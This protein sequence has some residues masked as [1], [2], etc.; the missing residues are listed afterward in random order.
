M[1]GQRQGGV[2]PARH[3]TGVILS[4]PEGTA[5]AQPFYCPFC[6]EEDF[7]P[8]ENPGEYYCESCNRRFEVKMLGLGN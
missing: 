2:R 6:G 7:I 8:I 4:Q 5:R 1:G 3:D